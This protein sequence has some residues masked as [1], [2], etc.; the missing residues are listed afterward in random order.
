MIQPK[1]KTP[2]K[3]FLL[4]EP[5]CVQCATQLGPFP[6]FHVETYSICLL[7]LAG[8]LCAELAM[9]R[10]QQRGTKSYY[11]N[12]NSFYTALLS[13]DALMSARVQGRAQADA[14]FASLLYFHIRNRMLMPY[15][16]PFEV[17]LL[18]FNVF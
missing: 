4:V 9:C 6:R 1:A 17:F 11:S 12:A 2:I 3:R 16:L 7:F 13:G 8:I 10:A 18:F 15:W 14:L 5:P